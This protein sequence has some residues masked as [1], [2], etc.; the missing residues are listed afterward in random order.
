VRIENG[1]LDF[2]RCVTIANHRHKKLP[3]L[4][5]ADEALIMLRIHVRLSHDLQFISTK[6]YEFA[7]KQMEELGKML[8]GWIKSQPA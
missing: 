4:Q 7:C 5:L 6:S 1:I 2:I 3:M 8:G